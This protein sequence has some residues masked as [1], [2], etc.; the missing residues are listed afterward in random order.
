MSDDLNEK[1]AS[2]RYEHIALSET[3][4]EK[5]SNWIEQIGVKK[6]GVR[7]SRKD[8]VN[9]LVEK[10]PEN[11]SN[12]DLN[13]LID[14]FYD[15]ASFLRQLLREVKNA[16][17]NGQTE[18][19]LEFIVRAKRLDQKKEESVSASEEAGEQLLLASKKNDVE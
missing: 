16:K 6:K 1:K 12:G 5:I 3:A 8:F 10:S 14:R 13:S 7:I 9:W 15:E 11:L 18:P 4:S 19:A 2:M 17:K